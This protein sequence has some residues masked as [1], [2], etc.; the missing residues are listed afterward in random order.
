MLGLSFI[1]FQG[2]NEMNELVKVL[3]V[4]CLVCSE[5]QMAKGY[6]RKQSLIDIVY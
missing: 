2:E 5:W 6:H 3:L 4:T 1:I